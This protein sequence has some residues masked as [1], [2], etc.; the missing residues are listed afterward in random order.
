MFGIRLA[1]G[2][3][4]FTMFYLFVKFQIINLR[5]GYSQFFSLPPVKTVDTLLYPTI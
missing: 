2:N 4:I 5:D 1:V 3:L